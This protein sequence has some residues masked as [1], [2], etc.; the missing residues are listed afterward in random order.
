VDDSSHARHIQRDEF[1]FHR[2]MLPT[3]AS[4]ATSPRRDFLTPEIRA[5]MEAV[6]RKRGQP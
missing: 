1:Y 3:S 5:K 2:P 6:K 4:D